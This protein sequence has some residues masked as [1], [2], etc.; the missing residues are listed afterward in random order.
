MV[1]DLK[2]L[3][4][5][6]EDLEDYTDKSVEPDCFDDCVLGQMSKCKTIH[7]G[8]ELSLRMFRCSPQ[9]LPLPEATAEAK[10]SVQLATD[11]LI[12]AFHGL[13][14]AG[15]GRPGFEAHEP[16]AVVE[17]PR[18]K[19]SK[20]TT[21]ITW[22]TLYASPD[23]LSFDASLAST[24]LTGPGSELDLALLLQTSAVSDESRSKTRSNTS[25][26]P[27]DL[28]P[29]PTKYDHA[30][31]Q[32]NLPSKM[33]VLNHRNY[34]RHLLAVMHSDLYNGHKIALEPQSTY[35]TAH[36]IRL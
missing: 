8:L 17:S 19:A 25:A 33:T 5:L 1:S 26:E 14:E 4:N 36:D 13:S 9:K 12:V 18:T 7:N 31:F 28:P 27:D 32:M 6:L 24:M 3:G 11:G 15:K 21:P 2:R 22:C 23:P 16:S 30:P 10:A 20:S 29:R 34:Q 35:R